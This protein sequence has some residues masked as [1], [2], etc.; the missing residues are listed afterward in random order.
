[1]ASDHWT[2]FRSSPSKS[3]ACMQ[4]ASASSF[5][6]SNQ[7]M[8][9]SKLAHLLLVRLELLVLTYPVW[10]CPYRGSSVPEMGSSVPE[11]HWVKP[12]ETASKLALEGPEGFLTP[13]RPSSFPFIVSLV[14]PKQQA[15]DG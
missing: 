1:M 10:M 12:G 3:S 7:N 11:V 4:L 13:S 9:A 15:A 5:W 2:H 14:R 6:S 8:P